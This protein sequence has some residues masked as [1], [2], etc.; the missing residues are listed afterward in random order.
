MLN[1]D[2]SGGGGGGE[3]NAKYVSFIYKSS[4]LMVRIRITSVKNWYVFFFQ[5]CRIDTNR[6]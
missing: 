1:F 2:D 4:V 5:M 6:Y 3:I